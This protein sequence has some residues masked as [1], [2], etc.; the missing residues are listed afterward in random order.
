LSDTTIYEPYIRALQVTRNV[1]VVRLVNIS[2]PLSRLDILVQASTLTPHPSGF[3]YT[4]YTLYSIPYT[5]YPMPYALYPI[6]YT[7][8]PIPRTLYPIHYTLP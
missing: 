8:F 1:T 7:L 4:P 6:P 2:S 5:L 3:I